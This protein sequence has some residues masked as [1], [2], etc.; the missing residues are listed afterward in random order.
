MSSQLPLL[1]IPPVLAKRFL[2]TRKSEKEQK[3]RKRK[4]NEEQ[5]RVKERSSRNMR[6]HIDRYL[7]VDV[8]ERIDRSTKL[9]VN[10]QGKES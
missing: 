10:R 9:T 2:K 8:E 3:E 5:A 6:R 1:S 4:T 7:R